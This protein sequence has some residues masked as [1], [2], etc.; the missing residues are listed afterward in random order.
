MDLTAIREALAGQIT[1]YTGLRSM[2]QAR[3]QVS[4]PVAVILPGQPF[5]TFGATFDGAL[6]LNLRVLILVGD[7][8]PS[9]KAQR[10]LDAWLGIG[11]GE[12]ASVPDAVTS[13]PTLA[14]A[15]AW[16][17]PMTVSQ[18]G[19]ISYADVP[20]WGAVLNLACGT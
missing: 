15:V 14:G 10:S 18:Y 12:P 8:A 3:D 20:Y 16:A 19:R 7:A 17:E 6:T 1:A 13:D 9:E 4:P 11:G 2:A 5:V